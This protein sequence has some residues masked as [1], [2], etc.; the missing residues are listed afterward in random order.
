LP[1][2][3]TRAGARRRYP[4]DYTRRC[5]RLPRTLLRSTAGCDSPRGPTRTPGSPPRRARRGRGCGLLHRGEAGA[6]RARSSV[7][8]FLSGRREPNADGDCRIERVTATSLVARRW[9]VLVQGGHRVMRTAPFQVGDAELE[10]RRWLTGDRS[11]D[12]RPGPRLERACGGPG[13]RLAARSRDVAATRGCR[14]SASRSDRR[15]Q[16]G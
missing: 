12:S 9:L 3:P 11:A 6:P 8:A 14:S 16:R 2:E 5:A 7:P 10:L 4:W 1:V 15:G 13:A